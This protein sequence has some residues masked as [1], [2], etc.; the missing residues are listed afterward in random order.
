MF[1]DTR[2][3]S[4]RDAMR[5]GCAR[6][7]D[8]HGDSNVF[9]RSACWSGTLYVHIV[10]RWQKDEA[11]VLPNFNIENLQ[12]IYS[13]VSKNSS[14]IP[15]N[16]QGVAYNSASR[17]L[18][19]RRRSTASTALHLSSRLFRPGSWDLWNTVSR[20]RT[21]NS[22]RTR[23]AES[24]LPETET[25]IRLVLPYDI[26]HESV[27]RTQQTWRNG[28]SLTYTCYSYTRLKHFNMIYFN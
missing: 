17:D 21:A 15:G 10:G 4:D 16:I 23:H 18:N 13:D 27:R 3:P 25:T 26:Q 9:Q 2:R 22:S 1:M 20:L 24:H 6:N 28:R 14:F 8:L 5:E 12:D 11:R 19:L 7:F